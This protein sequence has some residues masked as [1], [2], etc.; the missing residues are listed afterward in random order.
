MTKNL[1]IVFL[2]LF[3]VLGVAQKPVP[4]L[5]T[6]I[7]QASLEPSPFAASVILASPPAQNPPRRSYWRAIAQTSGVSD[8]ILATSG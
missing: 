4:T 1:L 5:P 8:T 2:L 7:T 3:T 6:G